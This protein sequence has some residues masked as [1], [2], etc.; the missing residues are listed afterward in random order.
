MV[1]SYVTVVKYQTQETDNG[2]MWVYGS[3]VGG[4]MVP[5]DVKVLL[6][7]TCEYVM[8]QQRG[9]KFTG[10]IKVTNKLNLK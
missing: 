5:K 4:I 7:G 6:R 1:T 9:I 2:T 3:V 8:L 10:E